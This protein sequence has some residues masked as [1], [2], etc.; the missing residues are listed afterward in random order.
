MS[1]KQI[2]ERGVFIAWWS[3]AAAVVYALI[4]VG[5]LLERTGTL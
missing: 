4:E 3:V 5:L 2:Q 1:W